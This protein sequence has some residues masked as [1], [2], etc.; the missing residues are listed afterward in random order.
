VAAEFRMKLLAQLTGLATGVTKEMSINCATVTTP[1][2]DTFHRQSQ[3]TIDT[4]EAL[5]IGDVTTELVVIIFAPT[6]AIDVDLNYSSSFSADFTI[7]IGQFAVIP[8]PVG[9][10]YL[11]NNT[12]TT[13]FVADIATI[14]TIA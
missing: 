8:K 7:P 2:I 5:N 1:D 4:A 11:N 13:K 12:G 6:V 3:A 14:G 10:I 9:L